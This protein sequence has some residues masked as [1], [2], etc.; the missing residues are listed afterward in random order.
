V[1]AILDPASTSSSSSEQVA[2]RVAGSISFRGR[3]QPVGAGPL[4]EPLIA[5]VNA[6]RLTTVGVQDASASA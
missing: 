2:P 5:A 4:P 1:L 6:I 3:R